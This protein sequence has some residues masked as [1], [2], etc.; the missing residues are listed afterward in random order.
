MKRAMIGLVIL[1]L[2]MV[3]C[4]RQAQVP[5]VPV[6]T[7]EVTSTLEPVTEVTTEA[8]AEEVV[9]SEEVYVP[10]LL[11][12]D[13]QL[14]N[15]EYRYGLTDLTGETIVPYEYNYIEFLEGA[16][17]FVVFSDEGKYIVDMVTGDMS[18][19]IPEGEGLEAEDR[20]AFGSDIVRYQDQTT[21]LYGYEKDGK[22]LTEA[23]Y[24]EAMPFMDGFA[25]V[26][27]GGYYEGTFSVIDENMN[28]IFDH[29]MKIIP[30]G[31]G[32][33][34]LV[35]EFPLFNDAYNRVYLVN[36]QGKKILD[37][38]LF[39]VDVIHQNLLL[40]ADHEKGWLIDGSGDPVIARGDSV[41]LFDSYERAVVLDGDIVLYND[42]YDESRFTIVD[43]EG[44][45]LYSAIDDTYDQV[46]DLGNGFSVTEDIRVKD[47]FTHISIPILKSD[48]NDGRFREANSIFESL[49]ESDAYENRQIE[50]V[51]EEY[52]VTYD[53]VRVG[54]I[55]EINVSYYWYGF[56]AA[57]P[58]HCR[59]TIHVDLKT[60]AIYELKDMMQSEDIYDVVQ[61]LVRQRAAL[62]SQWYFSVEGIYVDETV[63]YTLGQDGINLYYC[64]YDIAPY[65]AGYPEFHIPYEDIMP[66]FN[67]YSSY[68]SHS[69]IGD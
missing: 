54:D 67:I 40:V 52:E 35:Q 59:E 10:K 28:V 26:S 29:E 57:H 69:G 22:A 30:Y 53:A 38:Q 55:A 63:S 1:G 6:T 20:L 9:S 36:A 34:G 51:Y 14:I 41:G 58:N 61:T 12:V 11:K 3:G 16:A 25:V 23:V 7:T 17:S 31:E 65:A 64:P 45:L 39:E 24:Y 50:D 46:Q 37:R 43:E 5:E 66:Y 48:E 4:G 62:S 15:E 21:G 13:Y 42:G 19:L 32:Y 44:N 68:Y 56:G 8:V 33:F 27:D 49:A 18:D 2:M 47:R 60:G